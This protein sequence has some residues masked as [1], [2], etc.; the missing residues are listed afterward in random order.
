MPTLKITP[1]RPKVGEQ[2][3]ISGSGFTVPKPHRTEGGGDTFID[4]YV[5]ITVSYAMAFTCSVSI[6]S[7]RSP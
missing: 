1:A 2:Y 3:T 5:R 7:V 4:L 6:H